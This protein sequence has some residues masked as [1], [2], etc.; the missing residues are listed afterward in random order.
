[1]PCVLFLVGHFG[2]EFRPAARMV[3]VPKRESTPPPSCSPAPSL[4]KEGPH[5]LTPLQVTKQVLKT[6]NKE[7]RPVPSW[8]QSQG[9]Y[10]YTGTFW[11]P[12]SRS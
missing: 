11:N 8:L 6:C 7:A 2:L 5:Q 9:K 1:M 12:G 10:N 4:I 3:I